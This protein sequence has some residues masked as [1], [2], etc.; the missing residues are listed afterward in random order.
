MIM[1][2]P[3][4]LAAAALLL[5]SSISQAAEVT[6]AGT[7]TPVALG[8][9]CSN[10][11]GSFNSNDTGYSC[12]KENCNGKGGTCSVQC[13]SNGKCT[14]DTPPM[15]LPTYGVTLLGI[16]QAGN[17]VY[18][19]P[20]TGGTTPGSTGTAG[21]PDSDTGMTLYIPPIPPIN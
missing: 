10:A 4:G 18:R 14:G 3:K 20:S 8:R 19:E 13:G 6:I 9:A 1:G 11:G 21:T 5:A 2:F 7:I 17:N 12:V 15:V 16:L